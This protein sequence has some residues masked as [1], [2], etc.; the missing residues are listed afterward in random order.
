MYFWSLEPCTIQAKINPEGEV[1]IVHK[2]SMTNMRKHVRDDNFN[3]FGV[4]W[5]GGTDDYP[6][7]STDS[8]GVCA[9]VEGE[10]CLCDTSIVETPVFTSKP[11]S[12][13]D[14]LSQAHIG[15]PDPTTFDLN[16]YTIAEVGDGFTVYQK[17]SDALYGTSTIFEVFDGK[18]GVKLLK[19]TKSMVQLPGKHSLQWKKGNLFLLCECYAYYIF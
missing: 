17:A 19:N 14:I 4:G 8:C 13:Y 18:G 12:A 7:A 16:E 5:S 2:T 11:S 3:Y 10:N 6:K 9:V 15:A 1:T